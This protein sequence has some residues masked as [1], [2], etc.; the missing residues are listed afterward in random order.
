M[1]MAHN[2]AYCNPQTLPSSCYS[3][4]EYF[5]NVNDM[6]PIAQCSSKVCSLKQ[7]FSYFP[8]L[9]HQFVTPNK[10]Y[11]F[12]KKEKLIWIMNYSSLS[13]WLAYTR[14]R[15]NSPFIRFLL[16]FTI[17]SRAALISIF[18]F[19]FS[20]RWNEADGGER[21]AGE[22]EE[23]NKGYFPAFARTKWNF[24]RKIRPYFLPSTPFQ[25][26]RTHFILLF[27]AGFFFVDR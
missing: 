14:P 9:F 20:A 11:Y 3:T 13:L 26:W 18:F 2:K 7:F 10:K 16:V 1:V 21:W 22:W 12:G 6:P 17:H 25:P 24:N 23:K 19:S 27:A 5:Q 8:F 4:F 15:K